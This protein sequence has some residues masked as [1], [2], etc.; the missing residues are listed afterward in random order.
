MPQMDVCA[1]ESRPIVP[2]TARLPHSEFIGPCRCRVAVLRA[3]LALLVAAPATNATGACRP[4]GRWAGFGGSGWARLTWAVHFRPP[5]T[6][7]RDRD[8][9]R[10]RPGARCGRRV[11]CA[12]FRARARTSRWD[13]RSR[14][15]L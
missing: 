6:D 2:A 10:F 1:P 13:G 14:T 5:R 7:C 4:E 9:A 12:P 15:A 3:A 11:P 8:I